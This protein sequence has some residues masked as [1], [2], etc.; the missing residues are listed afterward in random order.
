[1]ALEL[2]RLFGPYVFLKALG[3]GAMG[4]VHL[5]RPFHPDRGIPEVVVVKRLHGDLTSKRAFVARFKHEAALAV[6]VD[7]DHVA[8]VYDVG[9]VGDALYIVMEHVDGWPLSKV[10]DEILKSGHHASVASVVDLIAGGLH[11]LRALHT[12]KDAD[13][14]K[15]L[16]IVHRDISR[17]TSWCARMAASF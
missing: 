14:G 5:A 4:D 13:S 16:G 8:K 15:D 11:G 7:N 9:A 10:L 1:M 3:R 17:R 12:A 2:P 6:S